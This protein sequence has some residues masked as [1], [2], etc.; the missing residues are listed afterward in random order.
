MESKGFGDI[1]TFFYLVVFDRDGRVM[2]RIKK[3]VIYTAIVG[4]YDDVPNYKV[5][6]ERF[7]YILFSD[8]INPGRIGIWEVRPIH[9][10]HE[11]KTKV[12]RWVKTHPEELLPEYESSMWL[13]ASF[14]IKSSYVYDKFISLMQSPYLIST[15][16]N[17]D[18]ICIYQEMCSMM[19]LHWEQEDIIIE[20][21][22]FLRKE[23]YPRWIGSYETGQLFRKHSN[24]KVKMFDLKWWHCI[25]KFARR[26]QFSFPYLLW[27][28]NLRIVPFL[29]ADVDTNNN[30]YLVLGNHA[31]DK[32]KIVG[33]KSCHLIRYYRKHVDER[34]TIENVLYWIYGRRHPFFLLQLI[35][36]LFRAKHVVL[37]CFGKKN[38]TDYLAEIERMRKLNFG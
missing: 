1:L 18:V 34:E 3:Y 5:I 32:N 31:N 10:T 11:I 24:P 22:R 38:N 8:S 14:V 26:D 30:E 35:G 15:N 9:F 6:D 23:N 37:C 28:L 20:W 25:E 7:D 21:G 12:A 33:G 16:P 19:Y 29:P 2:K 36:L 27:K 4:D 17:P 13:D